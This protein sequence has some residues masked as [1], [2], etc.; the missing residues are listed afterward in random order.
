MK[1]EFS[2]WSGGIDLLRDAHKIDF[3]LLERVEEFNQMLE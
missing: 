2:A 3:P 1:N